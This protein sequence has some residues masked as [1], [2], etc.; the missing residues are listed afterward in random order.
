MAHNLAAA[1]LSLSLRPRRTALQLTNSPNN[2]TDERQR[3][4]RTAAAAAA[5]AATAASVTAAAADYASSGR[6]PTWAGW[7]SDACCWLRDG[8]SWQSTDAT[9]HADSRPGICSAA[10]LRWPDVPTSHKSGTS[11]TGKLLWLTDFCAKISVYACSF[12][13][14]S[15][16]RGEDTTEDTTEDTIITA[17]AQQA[18]EDA[19][20]K[21]EEGGAEEGIEGMVGERAIEKMDDTMDEEIVV[22][23][24]ETHM[25]DEAGHTMVRTEQ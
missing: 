7:W 2:A 8:G 24:A 1:V 22:L 5:T 25:V 9:P 21:T 3:K 13:F 11:G 15:A 17:I 14:I 19:N 16:Y 18:S 6:I 23:G 4:F 20:S 10:R 12:V